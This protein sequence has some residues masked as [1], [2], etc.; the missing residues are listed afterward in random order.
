MASS[1][2]SRM[3]AE[4]VKEF[5][6]CL[7]KTGIPPNQHFAELVEILKAHKM[8][9]SSSGPLNPKLFLTHSKNRGGLL[10]SP[11][12]AHKNAA[13]IAAAGADIEALTSAWCVELGMDGPKRQE[14]VCKNE[15]LMRCH[16]RKPKQKQL[17]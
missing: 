13:N 3:S 10:L 8:C 12:N 9:Y 15:K 17:L 1:A 4:F 16:R 7:A 6:I 2:K 14:I 11:H 5:G